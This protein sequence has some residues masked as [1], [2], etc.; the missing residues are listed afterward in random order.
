MVP[1]GVLALLTVL[2]IVACALASRDPSIDRRSAASLMLVLTGWLV[3]LTVDTVVEWNLLEVPAMSSEEEPETL[4]ADT[5]EEPQPLPDYRTF[6][7]YT[8]ILVVLL[9]SPLWTLGV[10]LAIAGLFGLSGKQRNYQGRGL[11]VLA[12]LIVALHIVLLGVVTSG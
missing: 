11:A 3:L 12:I 10:A 5:V 1:Y 6:S 9:V 2:V 7:E 8:V 4:T